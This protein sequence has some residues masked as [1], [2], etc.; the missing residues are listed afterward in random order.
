MIPIKRPRIHHIHRPQPRLSREHDDA[1]LGSDVFA[2][3]AFELA[4]GVVRDRV[5]EDGA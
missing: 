1:V 5:D 4:V 3:E 2:R